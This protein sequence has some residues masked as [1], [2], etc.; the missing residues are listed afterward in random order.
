M[1]SRN[2]PAFLL[3]AAANPLRVLDCLKSDGQAEEK[4]NS[5]IC[6]SMGAGEESRQV[7]SPP[8]QERDSEI[9]DNGHKKEAETSQ[10]LHFSPLGPVN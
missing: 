5:G 7:P 1:L 2:P 10:G 6:G 3:F 9:D 4:N 8:S